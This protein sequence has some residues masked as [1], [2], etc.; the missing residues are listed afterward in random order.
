MKVHI[1]QIFYVISA[2]PFHFFLYISYLNQ[3]RGR[4]KCFFDIALVVFPE[5]YLKLELFLC[6]EYASYSVVF[7]AFAIVIQLLEKKT[8]MNAIRILWSKYRTKLILL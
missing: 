5:Q 2:F 1:K 4:W 8:M 6:W 3:I 7:E